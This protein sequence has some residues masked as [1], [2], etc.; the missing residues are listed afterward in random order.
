MTASR[1]AALRAFLEQQQVDAVVVNKLAHLHYF[2]GFRGDDTNLVITRKHAILVI[3]I[4]FV[5]LCY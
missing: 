5:F 1:L 4:S 2:S 3:L